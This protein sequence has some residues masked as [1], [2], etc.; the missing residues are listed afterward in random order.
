MLHTV[1]KKRNIRYL[2][3]LPRKSKL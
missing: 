1:R 2:F 3:R